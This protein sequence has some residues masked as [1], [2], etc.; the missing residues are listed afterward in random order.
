MRINSTLGRGDDGVPAVILYD[1]D[2]TLVDAWAGIA[3]AQNAAFRAFDMPTWTVA[4][5]RA[6]VRGSLRDSYPALF[7]AEW[8]RARDIFYETLAA[9]HLDHIQPLPG[10]GAAVAAFP[11]TRQAVVSNKAGDFLRKEVTHLGWSGFF[12]A[13]LGAG[14]AARD[15][16]HAE[17]LLLALATIGYEP[18]P[19]VW[20]IGDTALDMQAARKAGCRAVLIGDAAHDGG[21]ARAAPDMR[22]SD[23]G[24]L[25]LIL[26]CETGAAT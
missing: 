15:K 26:A 2:N 4:E 10:A 20:Y 13:I 14:D 17:P 8:T 9:S 3:Y 21:A 12:S 24:A 22:I 23:L 7:G 5:T 25:R 16:P 1:W 18:G 11:A 19:D 6:N